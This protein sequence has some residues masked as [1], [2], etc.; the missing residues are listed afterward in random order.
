VIVTN[1]IY[2]KEAIV[3][4]DLRKWGVLMAVVFTGLSALYIFW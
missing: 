1:S 2:D 3:D 4:I